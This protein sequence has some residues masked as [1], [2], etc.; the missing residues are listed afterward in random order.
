[1]GML[2]TGA[3]TVIIYLGS[4]LPSL[5]W[6][7]M[8]GVVR[9]GTSTLYQ[10]VLQDTASTN[11]MVLRLVQEWTMT[12]RGCFGPSKAYLQSYLCGREREGQ[13]SLACCSPS[14]HKESD[15]T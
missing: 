10:E 4:L 5:L 12:T 13:G 7:Y 9:V 3:S 14:G 6:G 2:D 1:M 15:L 11:P 8:L